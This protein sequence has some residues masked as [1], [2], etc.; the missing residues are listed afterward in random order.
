MRKAKKPLVL[1]VSVFVTTGLLYSSLCNLSCALLNCSPLSQAKM[2]E[3]PEPSGHCHQATGESDSREAS[4]PK[5]DNDQDSDQG[6][7]H[8]SGPGNCSA[9]LESSGLMPSGVSGA[10]VRSHTA[11]PP[12]VVPSAAAYAGFIDPPSRYAES[13]PFR[14]P[15]KRAVISVYRI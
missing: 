3:P 7:K 14:S 15:P 11:Q 9:H 8:H 5:Q 13:R 12:A 4:T 10:V 6:D 1:A 2:A